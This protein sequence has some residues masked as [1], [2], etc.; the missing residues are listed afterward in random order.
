LLGFDGGTD[1][2][3]RRYTCAISPAFEVEQGEN[4]KDAESHETTKVVAAWDGN[5]KT[6]EVRFGGKL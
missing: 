3:P 4:A 1:D 5:G 6:H 2:V